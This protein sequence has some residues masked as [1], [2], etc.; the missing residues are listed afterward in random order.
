MRSYTCSSC[1]GVARRASTRIQSGARGIAETSTNRK[2]PWFELGRPDILFSPVPAD[3]FNAP[4]SMFLHHPRRTLAADLIVERRANVVEF[5]AFGNR[6]PGDECTTVTCKGDERVFSQ[7]L[8]PLAQRPAP[9]R[10]RAASVLSFSRS[11]TRKLPSKIMRS[12]S[13]LSV[14]ECSR[15]NSSGDDRVDMNLYIT[16]SYGWTSISFDRSP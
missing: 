7:R 8:K 4:A 14:G 13:S 10:K 11:P 5:V 1:S 15:T 16:Y 2:V 12:S 3:S 6:H 9:G